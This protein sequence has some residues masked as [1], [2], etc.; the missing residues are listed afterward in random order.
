[1]RFHV[2]HAVWCPSCGWFGRKARRR[3][4]AADAAGHMR[5]AAQIAREIRQERRD[6]V[7]RETDGGLFARMVELGPDPVPWEALLAPPV[8]PT[9]SIGIEAEWPT[10][11]RKPYPAVSL[12]DH[13]EGYP[14]TD[15]CTHYPAGEQIITVM[16]NPTPDEQRR[17]WFNLPEGGPW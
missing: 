2:E 6:K 16:P 13:A 10:V 8:T 17:T 3:N 15:Q 1:M 5:W 14:C 4:R 12:H 9:P 11:I 7:F